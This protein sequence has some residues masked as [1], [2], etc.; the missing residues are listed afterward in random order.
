MTVQ[1]LA[2]YMEQSA[3]GDELGFHSKINKNY[4]NMA[5]YFPDFF[6][7]MDTA[8]ANLSV[9]QVHYLSLAYRSEEGF[10]VHFVITQVIPGFERYLTKDA[11]EKRV[12]LLL[13]CEIEP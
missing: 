4:I 8:Q 3:E 5:K 12:F 6:L 13:E 9:Q 2:S 1:M 10:R 11:Q 7:V